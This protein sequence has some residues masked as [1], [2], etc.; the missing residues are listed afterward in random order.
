MKLVAVLW[1]MIAIIRKLPTYLHHQLSPLFGLP[2]AQ[3]REAGCDLSTVG[4]PPANTAQLLVCEML[5][6]QMVKTVSVR[7][8]SFV[9]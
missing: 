5:S 6:L 1:L 2:D 9:S 8:F 3:H 7:C 4:K